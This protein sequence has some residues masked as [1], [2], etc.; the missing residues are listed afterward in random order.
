VLDLASMCCPLLTMNLSD[1]TRFPP[2]IGWLGLAIALQLGNGD[3][4]Q[5]FRLAS[6]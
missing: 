5:D 3:S 6:S 2:N 4:D 1:T